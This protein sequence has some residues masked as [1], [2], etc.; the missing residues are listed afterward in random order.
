MSEFVES[1]FRSNAWRIGWS[2]DSVDRDRLRDFLSSGLFECAQDVCRAA[3]PASELYA[4]YCWPDGSWTAEV[5][6]DNL[7]HDGVGPTEAA[8]LINAIKRIL[9]HS[10]GAAPQH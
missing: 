4:S 10:E 2:L 7:L 1:S 5:L 3:F 9:Q 8:A 6:Y